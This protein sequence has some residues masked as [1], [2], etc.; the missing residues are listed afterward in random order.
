[1]NNIKLRVL[2]L[3]NYGFS[4]IQASLH[5]YIFNLHELNKICALFIYRIHACMNLS[6]N[7]KGYKSY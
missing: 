3:L 1:M 2:L 7:Y 6:K 5:S 4:Y